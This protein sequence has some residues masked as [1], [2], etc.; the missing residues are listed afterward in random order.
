MIVWIDSLTTE[1]MFF[2]GK[3][4]KTASVPSDSDKVV[5]INEAAAFVFR[6]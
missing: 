5:L 6:A 1:D 2:G 4:I 3:K